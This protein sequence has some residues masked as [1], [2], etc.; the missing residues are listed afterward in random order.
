MPNLDTPHLVRDWFV[1][2]RSCGPADRERDSSSSRDHNRAR[3]QV[4]LRVD[5]RVVYLHRRRPNRTLDYRR[6]DC[7]KATLA[8]PSGPAITAA[9]QDDRQRNHL[10]NS[11]YREACSPLQLPTPLC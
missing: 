1:S 6:P 7:Q 10:Q 9:R 11:A 4:E 3:N 8:P 5:G 2:R